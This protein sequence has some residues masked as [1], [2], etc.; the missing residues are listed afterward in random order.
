VRTPLLLLAAVA[1]ACSAG[2]SGPPPIEAAGTSGG[3]SIFGFD[4]YPG[5][6][7]ILGMAALRVREPAT[8]ERVELD[9]AEGQVELLAAGVSAGDASGSYCSSEGWPP[10]GYGS[11]AELAGYQVRPGDQPALVLYFRARSE[12]ARSEAVLLTYRD[13]D[14]DRH[15]LRIANDGFAVEPPRRADTPHRCVAD[16]WTS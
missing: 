12:R 16:R 6:V 14:G 2:V 4:P 3:V 13:E 7:N 9:L 1:T 11:S 10:K 15:T 5:D 8:L